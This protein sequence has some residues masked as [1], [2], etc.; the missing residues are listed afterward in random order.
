ML[1]EANKKTKKQKTS[2]IMMHFLI[3]RSGTQM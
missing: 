1:S 3:D 2:L